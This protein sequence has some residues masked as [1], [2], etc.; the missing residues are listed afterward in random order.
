MTRTGAPS[1]RLPHARVLT[2]VRP[3]TGD[4]L[5]DGDG[6]PRGASIFSKNT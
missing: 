5:G 2:V 3:A 6:V 4:G 1:I